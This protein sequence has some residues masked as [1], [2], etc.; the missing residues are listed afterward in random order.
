MVGFGQRGSRKS[1]L[2]L[3]SCITVT[4]PVLFFSSPSPFLPLALSLSLTLYPAVLV[5]EVKSFELNSG[6][7]TRK[8]C[9]NYGSDW[10][11]HSLSDELIT[12]RAVWSSLIAAVNA[13]NGSVHL[14]C[15]I[16]FNGSARKRLLKHDSR[17]LTISTGTLLTAQLQGQRKET[18]DTSQ[19][20]PWRPWR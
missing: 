15:C 13:L 19:M 14:Y 2:A 7:K 11:H 8:Q 6:D 12:L 20:C 10:T 16:V 18:E 3:A 9:I 17:R 1:T 4:F 5:L